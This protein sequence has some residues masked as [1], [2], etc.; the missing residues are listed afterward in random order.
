MIGILCMG[1]IIPNT[2]YATDSNVYEITADGEKETIVLY[3]L[4]GSFTVTIPKEIVLDAET[5]SSEYSITVKGDIPSDTS[6]CVSPEDKIPDMGGVNFYMVEQTVNKKDDVVA[7]V[8]QED[9]EWASVE[10]TQTGTSK[11]GSVSAPELT[12]GKWQGTLVFG[13]SFID[14]RESHTHNYVDGVCTECGETEPDA[15]EHI[16]SYIEN[17]TKVPTCTETGEKTLTCECGDIKTEVI[18]TAEHNYV[19]GVCTEC[20]ETEPDAGEHIHS[21]TESVTKEPTCTEAGEKTSTCECGDTKT[22]T[23]PATGHN[24]DS[25]MVTTDA[26][27]AEDG[28][29]TFTCSCGDSYTET[30]PALGHNYTDGTCSNCGEKEVVYSILRST[31]GETSDTSGFL[32]SLTEDSKFKRYKIHGVTIYSDP[33]KSVGHYLTDTD[34][35][36][37]TESQDGSVIAWMSLDQ[38]NNVYDAY[39]APTKEGVKIKAP[40]NCSYMFA[41][42]DRVYVYGLENI[43]FSATTNT[44]YMF[45]NSEV[46]RVDIPSTLTVI[47]NSAFCESEI[48]RF[49]LQNV[50]TIGNYAFK[51]CINITSITLPDNLEHLGEGAFK[52]CSALKS[53][54]I[55]QKITTIPK[56]AFGACIALDNVELPDTVTS[57]GNDAFSGCK[58]LTTVNYTGTQE[59]WNAITIG[60]YNDP[61]T[62]A[63]INYNYTG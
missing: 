9:M 21:Y 59:Q 63:T 29:K 8:T 1:N 51:D 37:I 49:Q 53:I 56:A 16:H 35:W 20:G 62:N 27:C 15:G 43:D 58:K 48:S 26:T 45:Y 47:G 55:P 34:C 50:K 31:A 7:T 24:Y 39:I 10:V 25:G 5:K 36:D 61:L 46:K 52:G 54:I 38:V 18:A 57:I 3:E 19:D 22:E 60:T 41:N 11:E 40:Q 13:I 12:S 6:V 42:M 32:G 44:N 2:V 17:I 23:I 30:I 28:I 33:E 4:G 14:K